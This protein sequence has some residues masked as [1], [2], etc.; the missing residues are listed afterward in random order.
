MGKIFMRISELLNSETIICGLMSQDKEC[1]IA[2]IAEPL[3]KISRIAVEELV[4]ILMERE[5]MGS[6]GIGSGIAIPHGKSKE[7]SEPMMAFGLSRNGI[8][9]ESLDKKPAHIFF[10]LLTPE[11]APNLHLKLLA[12][13]AK[14]LRNEPFRQRLLMAKTPDEVI[15]ILRDEEEAF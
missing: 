12:G 13:I 9:F 7:L 8:D 6:T 5:R 15:T 3:A 14:I 10:M 2:E 4:R 1:V 11:H